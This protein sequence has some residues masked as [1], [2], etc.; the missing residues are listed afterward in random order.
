MLQPKQLHVTLPQLCNSIDFVTESFKSSGRTYIA[1]W[2]KDNKI[3]IIIVQSCKI[4]LLPLEFQLAR[5]GM[6]VVLM[7]RSTQKL[8]KVAEIIGK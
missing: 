3:I 4:S 1:W 7:S 5:C 2:Y 6:N 8:E